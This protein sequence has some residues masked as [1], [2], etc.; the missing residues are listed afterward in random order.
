MLLAAAVALAGAVLWFPTWLTEE[1]S[2]LSATPSAAPGDVETIPLRPGSR[3]CLDDVPVPAARSHMRFR[4][5]TFLQSGQPLEITLAGPRYRAHARQD[6]SYIDNALLQV[7]FDEPERDTLAQ[8][9]I[10]NTGDRL[11]ALYGLTGPPLTMPS[12]T[13]IDGNYTTTHLTLAFDHEGRKSYLSE[14]G[15]IFARMA[16]FRPGWIGEWLYWALVPL[17]LLGVPALALWSFSRSA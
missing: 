10:R 8:V 13:T 16:R 3:V 6:T 1:R 4:V 11:V 14:A 5:G 15:T 17:L 2:L 7:P 9:C 12:K